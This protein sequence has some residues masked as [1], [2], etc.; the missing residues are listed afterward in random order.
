L[1]TDLP[2]APINLYDPGYTA[3]NGLPRVTIARHANGAPNSAP[4]SM[5]ANSVL[6][7]AINMGMADGHAEMAKLPNLLNYSWHLDWKVPS[8]PY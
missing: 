4:R 3:K 2:T 5:P 1:E 7:G 6:P 8:N